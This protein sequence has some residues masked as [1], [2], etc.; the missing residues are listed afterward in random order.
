MESC[1]TCIVDKIM[2]LCTFKCHQI[3]HIWM[4]VR[5]YTAQQ[6]WITQTASLCSHGSPSLG[7]KLL[8]EDISM[9]TGCEHMT[10]H[11]TKGY[12]YSDGSWAI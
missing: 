8:I 7:S 12:L 11:D 1:R 3:S 4:R 2:R 10:Q 6:L 5:F 9:I